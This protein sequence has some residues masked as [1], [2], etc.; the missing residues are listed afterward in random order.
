MPCEKTNST[1]LTAEKNKKRRNSVILSP[2]STHKELSSE[3]IFLS[4]GQHCQITCIEEVLDNYCKQGGWEEW[5]GIQVLLFGREP[6]PSGCVSYHKTCFLFWIYIK[7]WAWWKS[8]LSFFPCKL[9]GCWTFNQDL[10]Q[11]INQQ[12]NKSSL[13]A[14][15]HIKNKAN[16][17][18]NPT[19]RLQLQMQPIT[20]LIFQCLI[21]FLHKLWH[22]S[23]FQRNLLK[24]WTTVENVTLWPPGL[25]VTMSVPLLNCTRGDGWTGPWGGMI[26]RLLTL[27]SSR[28]EVRPVWET[29]KE[30]SQK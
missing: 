8:L 25:S 28:A 17:A 22:L 26:V 10:N 16:F 3:S 18:T 1:L 27:P 6:V 11:Q 29:P 30:L 15:L 19:C 2:G 21:W 12:W 4:S 20:V 23:E 24:Y 13:I 14:A 5:R 7:K 9:S